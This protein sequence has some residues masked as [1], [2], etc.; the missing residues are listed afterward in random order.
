MLRL[1]TPSRGVGQS[2]AWS[3]S[4]GRHFIC[5]LPTVAKRCTFRL[6]LCLSPGEHA[7]LVGDHQS[8]SGGS[9]F[10][11]RL[12]LLEHKP[13]GACASQL[14]KECGKEL[15]PSI[16]RIGDGLHIVMQFLRCPPII[17]VML[18]PNLEQFGDPLAGGVARLRFEDA[19]NRVSAAKRQ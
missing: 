7:R 15:A 4:E 8:V 6:T 18:I 11:G 5:R 10:T 1:S 12:L 19:V 2:C 14:I 16:L 3:Y 17:V 9:P 13:G